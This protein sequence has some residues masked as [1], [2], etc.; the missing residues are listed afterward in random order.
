[1]FP[2]KFKALVKK[3]SK[4]DFGML[5]ALRL[6]RMRKTGKDGFGMMSHSDL[7][8]AFL[9]IGFDPVSEPMC[10]SV[11]AAAP[12]L[13]VSDAKSVCKRLFSAA[14]RSGGVPT[15]VAVAEKCDEVCAMS[16]DVICKNGRFNPRELVSGEI[17][18]VEMEELSGGL[19]EASGVSGGI[20]GG[21][22]V[23]PDEGQ[24][25]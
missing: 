3:T 24:A 14:R 16:S 21:A 17:S 18:R 23:A 19:P 10:S 25:A 15:M 7:E 2:K 5:Y 8:R 22:G 9:W 4:I 6:E 11:F 20:V 13:S 1:M 12:G